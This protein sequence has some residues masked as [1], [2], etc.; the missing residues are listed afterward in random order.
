MPETLPTR[1]EM[2]AAMAVDYDWPD[3]VPEDVRA[4]VAESMDDYLVHWLTGL[5]RH[6]VKFSE[7]KKAAAELADLAKG[8][9]YGV[10]M[11]DIPEDSPAGELMTEFRSEID[12]RDLAG[13]GLEQ[14]AHVTVRYGIIGPIPDRLRAY[15]RS[16]GPF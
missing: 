9:K 14:D 12:R 16:L 4:E 15:L 3:D 5:Y 7:G 8:H 10:V 1:E 2:L 6:V 11:V 13:Q